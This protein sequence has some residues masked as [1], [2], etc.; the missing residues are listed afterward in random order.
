[1]FNEL[2]TMD[3]MFYKWSNVLL[4]ALEMIKTCC[5]SDL[6]VSAGGGPLVQN[7]ARWRGVLTAAASQTENSFKRDGWSQERSSTHDEDL[8]VH[9][10]MCL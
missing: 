9:F 4:R 6:C 5:Y 7:K 2:S 1:M 8:C 10:L 3:T